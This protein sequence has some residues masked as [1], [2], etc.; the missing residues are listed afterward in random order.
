VK[1]LQSKKTRTAGAIVIAAVVGALMSAC[2]SIATPTGMCGWI[3]GNG[4]GD[5][6]AR[7]HE[8]IWPDDNI[9]YD[10][11]TEEARY[12]PC[13]PRNFI[14]N[15]GSVEGLGDQFTPIEAVTADNTPVLV[16]IDA[17]WQLN[18][19]EDA[20]LK[21]AELCNKYAC[22]TT[23]AVAGSSNFA[24]EGW[25]GMLRENFSPAIT[26]AVQIAMKEIPDAIWQNQDEELIAQ[27]QEFT[28]VAFMNEIRERTGY[29]VDLFCGSG[30]SGWSDPEN[31]GADGN[32]FTCTQVRFDSALVEARDRQTQNN[33]TAQNQLE[34]DTSANQAR[35]DK[36]F[37]L[38]GDQT[39]FWLGVQDAVAECPSESTCN[40]YVGNVPAN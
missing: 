36:S 16:Q 7:V 24:T 27:L 29:N 1:F 32:T 30:N 28:S 39:H 33:A 12:V 8:V 13:G 4:E 5:N 6:D 20:L 2:S 34:L 17:L 10:T 3:V 21:F 25:N 35:Y 37:P 22:Y 9:S 14:I 15:D 31:A 18:Q 23:Q 40:F 38:Y 19:D 11:S 26:D